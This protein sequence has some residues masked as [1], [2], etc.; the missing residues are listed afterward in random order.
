MGEGGEGGLV[1]NTTSQGHSMNK[2]F[3]IQNF[4][5]RE[6]ID[7]RATSKIT[8][9]YDL[10]IAKKNFGFLQDIYKEDPI[11]KDLS[12][13]YHCVK[14]FCVYLC[15]LNPY[16]HANETYVE[17]LQN[18][19]LNLLCKL[20]KQN[21]FLIESREFKLAIQSKDKGESIKFCEK[22]ETLFHEQ[23][24][25]IYFRK[26]VA[27]TIESLF[28]AD[29]LKNKTVLNLSIFNSFEQELNGSKEYSLFF[30]K[31]HDHDVTRLIY[32]DK[33][34]YELLNQF[35][36]IY[37]NNS[38][39]ELPDSLINHEHSI[40]LYYVLLTELNIREQIKNHNWNP[41]T[42]RHT[43]LGLLLGS[44]Y[45]ND[46]FK[47]YQK[48]I[49]KLPSEERFSFEGFTNEGLTIKSRNSIF[50]LS[51][52]FLGMLFFNKKED[53]AYVTT[54][55]I[56]RSLKHFFQIKRLN[57]NIHFFIEPFDFNSFSNNNTID[58]FLFNKCDLLNLNRVLPYEKFVLN[59]IKNYETYEAPILKNQY[60]NI[61]FTSP[62]RAGLFGRILNKD[63]LITIKSLL[64]ISYIP[65]HIIQN[66]HNQSLFL[67]T[68]IHLV[69]F[70]HR[71]GLRNQIEKTIISHLMKIK[72]HCVYS[73][74]EELNQK[75]NVLINTSR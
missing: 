42:N 12:D 19:I 35:I 32:E 75:L 33:N 44:L 55:K 24:S 25:I 43:L 6:H 36:S 34:K 10:N 21:I 39:Q 41:E 60:S 46:N 74:A 2:L 18:M 30:E 23:I 53:I 64:T 56:S 62:L 17:D 72:V 13:I 16:V 8:F 57:K 15:S 29:T 70:K 9:I 52:M 58:N 73:H 4:Q 1:N 61:D 20:N 68:L 59:Y 3:F 5:F 40:W 37:Q 51:N 38:C 71:P 7:N 67:D 50:D 66:V 22:V 14:H 31:K 69:I 48:Y 65:D 45:R 63:E 28:F 47:K 26:N 11:F 49:S 27:A 54:D